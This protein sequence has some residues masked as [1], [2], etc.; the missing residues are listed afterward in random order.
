M[1]KKFLLYIAS[2][3]LLG[4]GFLSIDPTFSSEYT[5][6]S[7]NFEKIFYT[8]SLTSLVLLIS[9]SPVRGPVAGGPIFAW[10]T[11]LAAVLLM[12]A[13]CFL[14]ANPYGTLPWMQRSAYI[15]LKFRTTKLDL[16]KAQ[17]TTPEILIFGSSRAFSLDPQ[18]IEGILGKKAFNFSVEGGSPVDFLA[19]YNYQQSQKD[20]M[21]PL[22][23]LV[24]LVSPMIGVNVWEQRLPTQLALY[25]PTKLAIPFGGKFIAT[26]LNSKTLTDSTYISLYRINEQ[27][28]WQIFNDGRL[29]PEIPDREAYFQSISNNSRAVIIKNS[30]CNSLDSYGVTAIREL[31]KNTKRTHTAVVFYRSPLSIDFYNSVD[32]NT[33]LFIKCQTLFDEFMDSLQKNNPHVYFTDLSRYNSISDQ[34]L[35]VFIDY[36]HLAPNGA[37]MVIQ[38]LAPQLKEALQWASKNRK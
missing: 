14:L 5:I 7:S 8:L 28:T 21:D 37:D 16:Y 27:T 6:F 12:V 22:L 18:K 36:Q 11:A 13:S 3:L 2:V 4:I 10:K 9:S 32:T 29:E 23:I 24:E 20:S 30:Q 15:G 19:F 35:N 34:G 17:E 31:V 38:A 1:P 26:S 25:L 33:D